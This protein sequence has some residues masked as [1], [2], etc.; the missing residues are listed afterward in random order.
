MIA[1]PN[2]ACKAGLAGRAPGHPIQRRRITFHC[3]EVILMSFSLL[4][5]LN[6][7]PAISFL[8]VSVVCVTIALLGLLIVRK[9]YHETR[10]KENH[11]V[12]GVIFNAFGLIYAVLVAFVVYTSWTSYDS[13]VRY[14][15]M[16]VNKISSLFLDAEAFDEPMQTQ[17]R[18]ALTEY[19][20]A[21]VEEEWP[22]IASGGRV[23]RKALEAQ[24][25]I[26]SAY[27]N[28]DVRKI[29]N[30]YLYEESLHQLNAM[31]E[32][33]RLRLFSSRSSTPFEIWLVLIVGGTM[34]VLYTYFFGTKHLK[35]QCVMTAAYTIMISISLYLI[36]IFSHPFV[37]YG[38]VSDEP[39]K[40]MLQVFQR[41]L[42]S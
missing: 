25:K 34:S 26:F 15:E 18:V 8:I 38:A 6:I 22:I 31:S 14:V 4:F 30:T 41:R 17:I 13:A 35:A 21:V 37:G 2:P 7:H 36:Y 29:K 1:R 19:T 27:T 32:Y 33:R 20:K 28:V 3:A 42:G 23:G 24:R 39:F 5:L 11:E 16:E 10:L 40:T 12:A 9:Y